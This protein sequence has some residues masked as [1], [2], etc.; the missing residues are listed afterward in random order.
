MALIVTFL[1]SAGSA[2]TKSTVDDL[3]KADALI[4]SVSKQ[5]THVIKTFAGP[6]GLLGAVIENEVTK[7]RNIAWLSP[8][9]DVVVDGSLLSADNRDVL[10]EAKIQQGLILSPADALKQ[11]SAPASHS[12]LVGTGGPVLTVFFDPNCAYCHQLYDELAPEISAGHA[13]VR[14]VIVGTLK[15]S[16]APRAESILA[17]SN[18]AKALADNEERF[19]G[20]NEEGGFSIATQP[21]PELVAEVGNNSALFGKA[22]MVGTPSILYCDQ[23][24]AVQLA[25][26]VPADIKSFLTKAGECR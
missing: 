16:S 12:F 18:P 10:R 20:P 22:G 14:Y 5:G 8:H 1:S 26:G 4:Q 17:A 6:D 3:G 24:G 19:D 13:R 11:A 15:A 23:A 7:Q 25:P 2:A 21:D 9:A